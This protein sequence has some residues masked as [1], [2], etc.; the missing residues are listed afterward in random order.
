[1][2]TLNANSSTTN[3]WGHYPKKLQLTI[4]NPGGTLQWLTVSSQEVENGESVLSMPTGHAGKVN[5]CMRQHIPKAQRVLLEG[6]LAGCASDST[7]HM[8][9]NKKNLQGHMKASRAPGMCAEGTSIPTRPPSGDI[10]EDEI[11]LK[12]ER[13]AEYERGIGTPKNLTIE[14]RTLQECPEGIRSQHGVDMNV[15]SQTRGPGGQDEVN[16]TFGDVK[17]ELRSQTEGKQVETDG[18]WP[19]RWHNEQ[20]TLWLKMSQNEAAS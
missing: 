9:S 1:M 19:D 3:G 17:N 8:S 5:G 16:E 2:D 12:L 18:I 10:K 15:S 7:R 6:E 11:N 20:H 4:Y 13:L 14:S